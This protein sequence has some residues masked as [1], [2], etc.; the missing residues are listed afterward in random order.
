MS[1]HVAT[2]HQAV[3]EVF[4]RIVKDLQSLPTNAVED[5][6]H[7]AKYE[8]SDPEGALHQVAAQF[9]ARTA[10]AVLAVKCPKKSC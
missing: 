10:E 7:A 1:P 2:A 6:L 5:V 9:V 3:S 8:A 4:D